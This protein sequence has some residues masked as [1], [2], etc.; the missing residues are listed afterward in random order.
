MD[1]FSYCN[2][3]ADRA[4]AS[5]NARVTACAAPLLQQVQQ[6]AQLFAL[7]TTLV[8]SANIVSE[9]TNRNI[10]QNTFL[11]Q[12][13]TDNSILNIGAILP[14]KNLFLTLCNQLRKR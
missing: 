3:V 2:F 10:L 13:L 9:S 1:D 8:A 11:R 4:A 12:Q 7:I 5:G 14:N 6:N